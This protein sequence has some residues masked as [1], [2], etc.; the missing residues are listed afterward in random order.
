MTRFADPMVIQC[1][2]C[3]RR[4]RKSRLASIS[5]Y[6]RRTRVW[7]DGHTDISVLRGQS[8]LAH[9]PLCDGIFWHD[10]ATE[11]GVLPREPRRMDWLSTLHAKLTRDKDGR[12]AA[13]RRW[14]V[15]DEGLKNCPHCDIP[16]FDHFVAALNEISYLTPSRESIAR[17]AIW[18]KCN[19]SMRTKSDGTR[20]TGISGISE[21][22]AKQNLVALLQLHE[23]S[24]VNAPVE[25]AEILRQLGRF[26]EAITLLKA[27]GSG[28]GE[29]A[30]SRKIM[31][32]AVDRESTLMEV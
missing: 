19:D 32:F 15:M 16:Q 27:I 13:Q 4:L 11:I 12:L 14:N 25:R 5:G 23:C 2:K 22:F 20:C 28:D 1:P 21:S 26:D 17:R 7:S 3:H 31:K 10:D 30:L 6:G 8:P 18:W 24:I 9:C 29:F